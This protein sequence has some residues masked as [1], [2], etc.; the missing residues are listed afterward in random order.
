MNTIL[1]KQIVDDFIFV[2]II[3]CKSVLMHTWIETSLNL[4]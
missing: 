3:I 4:L 1:C 2:M